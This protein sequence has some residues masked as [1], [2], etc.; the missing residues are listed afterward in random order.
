VSMAV[1]PDVVASLET[2]LAKYCH[3]AVTAAQKAAL[4]ERHHG[5]GSGLVV[6]V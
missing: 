1:T 4:G 2:V 6:H 3:P 5:C